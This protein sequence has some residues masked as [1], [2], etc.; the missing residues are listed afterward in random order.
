MLS[1]GSKWVSA[2]PTG[3]SK[4]VSALPTGGSRWVSALP[5]GGSRW[6]QAQPAG[7]GWNRALPSAA[8]PTR[9]FPN[10]SGKPQ[11]PG[12]PIYASRIR[13]LSAGSKWL[14]ADRRYSTVAS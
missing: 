9:S 8:M 7:S 1:G 4:W 2:L 12:S 11:N 5:T 3:G 13:V 6:V 10:G 14:S